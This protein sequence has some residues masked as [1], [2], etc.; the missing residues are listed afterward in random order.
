[1]T[2]FFVRNPG[3]RTVQEFSTIP[4]LASSSSSHLILRMGPQASGLGEIEFYRKINSRN[5][6]FSIPSKNCAFYNAYTFLRTT[7]NL[8]RKQ[9][10]MWINILVWHI[11][12]TQQWKS[13]RYFSRYKIRGR[14]KGD[15]KTAEKARRRFGSGIGFC[16]HQGFHRDRWKAVCMELMWV[17]SK[18]R[19]KLSKYC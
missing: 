8:I 4:V 3:T 1:M 11:W 14:P 19:K 12:H 5:S 15:G 17:V 13:V 7:W 10:K 16:Q 2:T 6:L 18:Q 9:M